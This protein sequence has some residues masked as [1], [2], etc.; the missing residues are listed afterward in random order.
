MGLPAAVGGKL[1]ARIA[2]GVGINTSFGALNRFAMSETLEDNGYKDMAK[3]Y[4]VFDKQAIAVDAVLGASFGGLH[5]WTS[6][7]NALPE[8]VPESPPEL[9]TVP[10]DGTTVLSEPTPLA[11]SEAVA[12]PIADATT[13]DAAPTPTYES[14]IAEIQGLADNLL[15]VADRK[16]LAAEI[17][18]AEYSLSQIEAKRQDLRDQLVSNSSSRRIRN[19]DMAELDRQTQE[20]NNRIS[21]QRQALTDS[22][23]G[24]KHFEAKADLSRIEQGIIP[25]SMHGLVD[26]ATVKPSDV[27][28]AHVMNEGLHYDIESSPVVHGSNESLNAHVKAMDAA[29]RSLM[30]G[31]P[32]NV[33]QQIRGLEGV[34]KPN[35]EVQGVAYRDGMEAALHESGVSTM[36]PR[37]DTGMAEVPFRENSAF[38]GGQ[39]NAGKIST[40]P[41]TGEVL[42]ANSFDLMTARDLAA[43]A[44]AKVLHPDT[45]QEVTL[46]RALADLDEQI[47]IVQKESNVYSVAATCFLRNPS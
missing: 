40:D 26:E 8:S 28:A 41:D 13:M 38:A 12:S 34:A 2:S 24:G 35:A 6:S 32:V 16:A 27:D 31:E 7:R 1:L 33:S 14:R 10:E 3:Q 43:D 45:G 39:D 18:Q 20:I 11:A 46:S 42:S 47:A 9:A 30:N 15:P 25:D 5:H 21:P 44:D 37:A 36:A 4:Q 23:R 19:R 29:T 22:S 17:H